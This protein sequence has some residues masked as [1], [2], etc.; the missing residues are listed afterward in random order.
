MRVYEIF[1]SLQ[2]EGFMAGV[3]S[4][5]IRLAGCP[6][7]CRWCDTKYAWSDTQGSERSVD[8]IVESAGQWS[9]DR[10]VVTG[11]EPMI[12]E[13]LPQLVGRLRAAG[14]HV[15]IET[16]GIAHIPDMPCDLMSISPKL[17]NS[18]PVEAQLAAFHEAARLDVAVLAELVEN[19]DYQLKFV[20][21]SSDDLAEILRTISAIGNV[22]EQKVMLMPQA[23]TRDEFLARGPI[24][25]PE[26]HYFAMGD[27]RDNSSD[28]RCWGLVAEKHLVGK[29]FAIWMH[30]DGNRD[31]LPILGKIAW[32]RLGI[33]ID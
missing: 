24:K 15:T 20:V 28:S 4:V 33:L 2:G 7:R 13:D 18:V 23:S 11:G 16:A 6:L 10:V 8:E 14:K 29:A 3:P 31:G 5:F 22:D 19:H 1:H 9:C 21:E 12:N 25:V 32:S 17:G 26:G 27:N 30:Y